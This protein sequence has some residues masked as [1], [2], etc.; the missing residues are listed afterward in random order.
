MKPDVEELLQQDNRTIMRSIIQR[1]ATGPHMSKDITTEEA[2]AGMRAILEGDI[3][4]VQAALFLI[5]LRMK[6]ETDAENIGV[7]DGI[8]DVCIT[9]TAEVDDVLD[10]SDPY[11]GYNRSLPAA[12]FL[13]AVMAA[14][15]VPT[16]SHGVENMGPKFGITHHRVLRA[17]GIKVDDSVEQ[18]AAR[19]SSA[20]G[21]AYVDQ[22]AYCPPLH[23]LTSLRSKMVKRQA[24]TTVEVLTRPIRGRQRTHYMSGYVHKPYTEIYARLA[25]HS[26]FD[27]CLMVRGV[28]GGII[29]SLRQ[30]GKVFRYV[31]MGEETAQDFDPADIG[32]HHEVRATPLPED[33]PAAEA[34]DDV[35]ADFD[36]LAA[37]QLAAEAGIEALQGKTGTP[38]ADALVYAGAI[39]LWHLGQA[40][41]LQQGAETIRKVLE[42]GS[43]LERFNANSD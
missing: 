28:E 43:A 10:M 36:V 34:G 13:P 16:V 18:A 15:G 29:P 8:R 5:A 35:G 4:E 32:I 21:W 33:L 17:A 6:R 14:C 22:K 3:D 2:R 20:S 31:D 26:G 23:D 11:N 38:T 39:A 41:G 27:S 37:S 19:L 9:A 7:L 24:I 1:I 42:N 25:R 12:P 40:D 30:Q